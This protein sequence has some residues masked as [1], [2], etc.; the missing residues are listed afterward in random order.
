MWIGEHLAKRELGLEE[1]NLPLKS[2][3]RNVRH[4]DA[5]LI[6]WP[7][8][9]GELAIV[10]NPPYLGARKI[11]AELGDE[12]VE[13]LF[14]R[15]PDNRTADYVTY[16]FPKALSTLRPNE[17]AGLVC[18]NSI[19]QNESRKASIDRVVESGGTLTSAWKSYP[20]PGEAAV[21]V[22][23]V[24]WVMAEYDGL[25]FLDGVEV[26]AITP[27]L[28]GDLDMTTART[29]RENK[30]LC[31][32]GVT[33]GNKEFV[34]TEEQRQEI[35][36][37][38]P[39]SASV[40]RPF[41]IGMDVNRE[42][43]Q[44]PTRWVIDFGMMTKEEAERYPGAMRHV[45]KNVYAVKHSGSERKTEGELGRWW[46]FVRP[47]P[48]MRAALEPL[49]EAIV[50]PCVSPR[51]I[52]VRKSTSICFDHQLMV[53]A[54]SDAYHF[55][56][57][58]SRFHSL[59]ARARGSTLKGDLRYTNTTIFETYPFPVHPDGSYRPSVRP[60]TAA[61]QEVARAAK[62]FEESRAEE[63]RRLELGLTKLHNRLEDAELPG[64]QTAYDALNDAVAACY[65]F[66]ADVWRNEAATLRLLLDLNHRLSQSLE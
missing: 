47:R 48:E 52:A 56:I 55:G 28:S 42:I 17:R 21:H 66:P 26:P 58:Q 50:V 59:W 14:E 29:L 20:W 64:L 49:D 44:E 35:L 11:R 53:I 23:I 33:P 10:G 2:L 16:W 38:D 4:A 3:D 8:P 15:F 18:T 60:V 57:L 40:I 32:M 7:R 61:A 39:G 63:C 34:L 30:R 43:D 27:A 65:G 6:D 51:M 1:E 12:Y 41:L 36:E 5:L 45:R 19:A 54:L 25:R 62:A 37:T 46:Q 31:F 9:E 13:Q 22:S 24:N